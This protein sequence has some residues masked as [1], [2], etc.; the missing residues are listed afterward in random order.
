MGGTTVSYTVPPAAANPP[1][2]RPATVTAASY[3]LYLLAAL[4]LLNMA[5]S[6]ITMGTVM[7]VT[8]DAY[9]GTGPEGL[10]NIAGTIGV[11]AAVV[12]G[13]IFAAGYVTLGILNG[14]GKNAARIVTWVI[15]GIGVCCYGVGMT[16]RSLVGGFGGGGG[17]PGGGP[18]AAE[19]QERMMEALPSWHQPYTF[20]VALISLLAAVAVIVLLALPPSNEFF[21]KPQ[22]YG[23]Q[24]PPGYPPIG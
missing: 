6:L 16:G 23:W 15:T 17:Q 5:V 10:G 4:Q 1:R 14:K 12:S 8:N 20:T 24:Q 19:L 9:Q 18:S 13:L 7:D 21:R 11:I 22:P 2:P 3:L